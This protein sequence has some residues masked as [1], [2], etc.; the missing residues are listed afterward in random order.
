MPKRRREVEGDTDSDLSPPPPGL[1]DGGRDE[2]LTGKKIKRRNGTHVQTATDGVETE[3]GTPRRRAVKVKHETEAEENALKDKEDQP[4][5]K[6]SRKVKEED[7]E[8]AGVDQDGELVEKKPARKRKTKEEKEAEMLEVNAILSIST[9]QYVAL[10]R[11]L[12][13]HNSITNSV[14]IGANAFALF[15]KSQR[16][17]ANPP[18][19]S[20]ACT[21]FHHQCKEHAVDQSRHVVPHGSYLVNLAHTDPD[22]TTQ[23]Y[24]SFLDDLKRCE[25][26]GIKLYN[27][28]PGNSVGGDRQKAI[29][30]LAAN[31][32]RAHKATESVTTLLENMAAGG[33]VLGSTFE[34]LR[35]IIA[36]V[37][38]QTRVGVCLDTCHAFAAGYDLRSP[39]AF[40][41]TME[42]FDDIVGV[43]YLRAVHLND[44][45]A[46]FDSHRDLHANIGTGFL[47]LRAFHNLVNDVRF[48]G[49][50]LVLETPIAVRDE[51]GNLV[52]DEKNKEKEDK[53][54]W[55]R[56]IKMLE[57]LVGMDVE[58]EEFRAMEQ[59][60]MVSMGGIPMPC[61]AWCTKYCN[62]TLLDDKLYSHGENLHPLSSSFSGHKSSER[63]RSLL[64]A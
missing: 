22:R 28:H 24:D 9:H 13:V 56:E 11:D 32:N 1:I 15:L 6:R 36:L 43:K 46:P 62:G 3:R 21:S 26:L 58:S 47:E 12:G 2:S 23:A 8:K 55:A 52:R 33:N 57:G 54:I 5:K 4:A 31:I 20:E 29:A 41:T 10:S 63:S 30:H 16:K 34:D 45:K 48:E 35:D 44:S 37:H 60:A 39:T 50:P 25:S 61:A 53:G 19:A 18:L 14:H 40:R 59:S 17:W 38:D 51:A 64:M 42:Q 27:F 49:L 7:E